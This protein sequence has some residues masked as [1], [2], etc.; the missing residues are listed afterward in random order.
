MSGLLLSLW[1]A[2]QIDGAGG[3][4]TAA[5]IQAQLGPLLPPGV[6][7][8]AS[9]RARIAETPDG[10]DIALARSDGRTVARRRLPRTGTCV[11]QAE[12]V[13]VTLAVWEA[14]IHPEIS[15]RLDRLGTAPASGTPVVAAP[16]TEAELA[17]TVARTAGAR[18]VARPRALAVGA[19][20]VGSWQPGSIAPGGRVDAM[21]GAS[22]GSWRARLSLA[23]LG[24]HVMRVPPGEATWWRA[25]AAV[26]ADVLLPVGSR[27]QLTAGA[28]GLLG[29][30][31]TAGSGYSTDRTT[32]SF[33]V[34]VEALAR[35]ELPLGSIRPW[36]GVALLTW[37]RP[38]NVEV[39]GQAAHAALPRFEGLLALGA[40]FCWQP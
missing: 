29:A 11:E 1:L 12:T 24:Q 15:L 33:D 27:W 30:V 8:D 5:E 37:L 19:A 23:A 6:G 17:P 20:A 2:V 35:V 39:T 7:I 13:A 3:C 38:Q 34:G 32:R 25:Y 21:L 36:L 40:D 26:G 22:G 9:D 31:T 10:L 14:Q 28:A 18:P 4:P 16:R